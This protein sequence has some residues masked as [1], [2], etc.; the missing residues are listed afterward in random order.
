MQ[1]LFVAEPQLARCVA[2]DGAV[3]DVMTDLV[4]DVAEGDRLLVHAGAALG[5]LERDV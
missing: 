4:G 2:P 1:V 3:L 5:R